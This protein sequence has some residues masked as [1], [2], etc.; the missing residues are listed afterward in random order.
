MGSNM[1]TYFM[2]PLNRDIVKYI[3]GKKPAGRVLNVR[4]FVLRDGGWS[5]KSEL[6]G[7]TNKK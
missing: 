3:Q 1:I 6:W 4:M 2:Y 5:L 7:I